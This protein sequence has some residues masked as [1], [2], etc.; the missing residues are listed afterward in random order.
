M[1]VDSAPGKGSSFRLYL[2][3]SSRQAMRAAPAAVPQAVPSRTTTGT[4]LIADDESIVLETAD[5][6]LRHFGYNTVLARDGHEAIARFREN[7]KG[8]LVA[9]VD[10]TMPGLDGAE[11]MRMI[12]TINPSMPVLVMSG[13]S[14]QDVLKRLQGLGRVGIM[15]KPFSREMLL[16]QIAAAAAV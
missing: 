14:E 3:L 2:P 10:L 11:V 4:I 9:L 16:E 15:R 6:L 8:F 13:F 7:P 5:A 12:R 1:T